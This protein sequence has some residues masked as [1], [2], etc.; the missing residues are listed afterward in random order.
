MHCVLLLPAGVAT[1]WRIGLLMLRGDV[2]HGSAHRQG[3][4]K[5]QEWFPMTKTRMDS[6]SS[7]LYAS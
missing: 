5:Y 6:P 1:H 4:K 3:M 7:T 2:S